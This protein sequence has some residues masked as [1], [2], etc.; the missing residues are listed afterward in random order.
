MPG[1]HHPHALGCTGLQRALSDGALWLSWRADWHYL[2]PQAALP[3]C[4]GWLTRTRLH[5]K[6]HAKPCVVTPETLTHGSAVPFRAP[7]AASS[8]PQA[9]W[10]PCA[11]L[12]RR[13]GQ[14]CDV[15]LRAGPHAPDKDDGNPHQGH[16]HS[17]THARQDDG[18]GGRLA[19]ALRRALP[20]GWAGGWAG[21]GAGISWGGALGQ[22]RVLALAAVLLPRGRRPLAG[23]RP[24]RRWLRTQRSRVAP[25]CLKGAACGVRTMPGL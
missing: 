18:Q 22:G 9:H 12:A 14:R 15:H 11:A 25:V 1:G 3:R 16:P 7:A 23:P 5:A 17:S 21:L 10:P 6:P 19:A 20:R 13:H 8:V 24:H 2:V 4:P